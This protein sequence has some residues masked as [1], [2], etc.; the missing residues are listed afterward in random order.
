MKGFDPQAFAET[1]EAALLGGPRT[2]SPGQLSDR[3]NLARADGKRLW[4]SMG[5]AQ[6]E[7]ANYE[8]EISLTD[9]DLLN[10]HRVKRIIDLGIATFDEIVGMS[11]LTGQIFA[12]LADSEGELMF[13]LA[14]REPDSIESTFDRVTT[15]ILPFIEELHSYVWRRQLAAF[16]ARKAMAIGTDPHASYGATVG[17]VDISGFT[18][19]SRTADATELADLLELF[20]SIAT[21]AVGAR[22]GRVVKLIGDAVLYTSHEPEDG[23]G[24]AAELMETWPADRPPL[25]AGVAT[26]PVLRR[27]GDVFGPTVN[28]ASRLTSLGRSGE[29]R[30][31]EETATALQDDPRFELEEQEPR[32]VRGYDQLRSW[33]LSKVGE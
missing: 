4:R 26:G 24:I 8:T 9:L 11:R 3:A 31:D 2:M 21:D 20:E 29:I 7:D 23:A 5:F 15:E 32:G 16:V 18:A 1:V 33:S 12:Q 17:F 6:V 27:L 25:R 19:L 10:A 22:N 28:I 13:Q 30:V 14:L